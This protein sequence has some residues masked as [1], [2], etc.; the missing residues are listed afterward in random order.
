[1]VPQ[2]ER[3]S[4]PLITTKLSAP[5]LRAGL[6]ARP[7]LL[8]QLGESA[9]RACTLVCAS[10]GYGKT[11]LLVDWIAE[12]K[13]IPGSDRP[14]VCWLSLD[15]GDNEPIRFL[16]YLVA[17]IE[18]GG[19]G[20]SAE[21]GTMLRSITPPPLQT[22][23]AA[24]INDLAKL[25]NSIYL[26]LDDYHFVA[27][28]AI[29]ESMDFLL[30]H[31]PSNVHLVLATRSDPPV[32]LARLRARGQ[33]LEI[34][35]KDLQFTLPETAQLLNQ[36]MALEIR[37]ED[38][39]R[40]EERT[41][42]WVAG[43]KM[44]GMALRNQPD[45]S[46]FVRDF[47]GS[48]RYI[49]DYLVEEVLRLQP[50]PIQGFLLKTSILE[51]LCG[52]LC[53]AV[54]GSSPVKGAPSAQDILER[55]DKENL[56]LIS[57]DAER[58]WYRYHHL[59]ADLLHAR[60]AKEFSR[61]VP[62][63]HIRAAEWLEGNQH[64]SEAIDHYLAAQAYFPACRLIEMQVEALLGRNG[65]TFLMG[66]IG[67]LP[68]EVALTR[69]WLC[70]AQAWYAR[71]TDD[72]DRMES[73]LQAAERNISEQDPPNLRNTWRGHIA[74]LR[75]FIAERRGD[76]PGTIKM[77]LLAL[78]A[79]RPGDAANRNFARY[80]LGR[81]H[82][83]RG[84]LKEAAET[85]SETVR[86]CIETESTNIVAPTVAALSRLYR[87]E[88]RLREG[89]ELLK[90]ASA[91]ME[92][93]DP[94]LVTVAGTAFACRAY[95]LLERNELD[96]AE[97]LGI[98][99][100]R[101]CERW[102]HPTSICGCYCLLV[103][104][105]LAQGKLSAAAEAVRC[106]EE[107]IRGHS[108]FAEA[109]SELNA[110]R[111]RYWLADG[112]FSQASQW[113]DNYIKGRDPDSAFS[114]PKEQDEITRARI[115]VA[116][117]KF[118]LAI[119]TLERLTAAAETGQRFGNLIEILNLQALALHGRG[120]VTRAL[121]MLQKSLGLAEPEGYVRIY[122]G[123]GRALRKLL[124]TYVQSSSPLHKSYA[125]ELLAV[126][127]GTAAAATEKGRPPDLIEPLTARELEVLRLLAEGFSNRQIAE[128][129]VLSEG[130]IKFHVHHVIEKL[131]SHTRSEALAK[132]RKQKLI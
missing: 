118:D 89:M 78:D 116:S 88:G 132:A 44:V 14:I 56:F 126:Q 75:G 45:S 51:R 109:I 59:F 102:L 46:S 52:P 110:V 82:F 47:S 32:H 8:V 100:L 123:E 49:L 115:L 129:L 125:Q 22:I 103:R 131:Q 119:E 112:E 63:L 99:S 122:L 4:S 24:L 13:K 113:A 83:L 35:A 77:A 80:M 94:R 7:N 36:V 107:S 93:W 120:D 16:S 124:E 108:P 67:R 60:L 84:D 64:I 12:F 10:A 21:A 90:Q 71:F 74:C 39:S 91:H 98:R 26:V 29:H 76:L 9:E 73:F 27:N 95:L 117:G 20:I 1:L 38:V 85:L 70:I 19:A 34:R 68:A 92:R 55:L 6:V 65:M 114:I 96:A 87:V 130:T 69:P 121:V 28:T 43:L 54:M 33:L 42:G 101:L 40:L 81:A 53:D 23:L 97:E 5:Q 31:L 105:Y 79:L 18:T 61:D 62:G 57:L 104:V 127:N 50:T 66:W 15:E 58:S 48:N 106:A 111:V 2:A 37:P 25:A 128:T 86:A 41:E 72:V 3:F 30:H 17:A 11:T